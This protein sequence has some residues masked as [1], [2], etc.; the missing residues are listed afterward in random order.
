MHGMAF[1]GN[2]DEWLGARRRMFRTRGYRRVKLAGKKILSPVV[3]RSRFGREEEKTGQQSKQETGNGS[4]GRFRSS[5]D[6]SIDIQ[7]R[8]GG[9]DG[10]G[11]EDLLGTA[12]IR[13]IINAPTQ[14]RRTRTKSVTRSLQV[15][16]VS[17]TAALLMQS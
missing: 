15:G 8:A 9:N 2:E 4:G 16:N 12:N 10:G 17:D 13:E 7:V 11:E 1:S 6:N 5:M 14:S 3:A